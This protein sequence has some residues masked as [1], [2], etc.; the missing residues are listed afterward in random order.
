MTGVPLA[1]EPQIVLWPTWPDQL[2][3][4]ERMPL[5]PL[6]IDVRIIS[7]TQPATAEIP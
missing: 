1:E 5:V 3:R 7:R 2:K 4:L 6:R